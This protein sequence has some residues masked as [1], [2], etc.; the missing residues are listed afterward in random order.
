MKS[1]FLYNTFRF[2]RTVSL[3]GVILVWIISL[4]SSAHAYNLTGSIGRF[5]PDDG[6]VRDLFEASPVFSLRL[7]VPYRP[8]F[9]WTVTGTIL[10]LKSKLLDL[11]SYVD[12]LSVRMGFVKRFPDNEL[13][14]GLIEPLI[15]AG[16]SLLH[17]SEVLENEGDQSKTLQSPDLT[18]GVYWEIGLL[19]PF[20]WMTESWLEAKLTDQSIEKNILANIHLSGKIVSVG[21]RKAF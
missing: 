14:T 21:F 13:E 2:V 17:I 12:L 18:G 1:K 15:G 7:G 10:Q 3:T 4:L 6:I 11:E 20:K 9:D 16:I 19:F 5:D 8:S